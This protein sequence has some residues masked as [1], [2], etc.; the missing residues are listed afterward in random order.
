MAVLSPLLFATLF[1]CN[2][3]HAASACRA[4]LDKRG[5]LCR[6]Y[7]RLT[8][9]SRATFTHRLALRRTVLFLVALL[10]KVASSLKVLLDALLNEVCIGVTPLR[11]ASAI[12]FLFEK[13]CV[14]KRP[15]FPFNVHTKANARAT[16]RTYG[17]VSHDVS[18]LCYRQL[19]HGSATHAISFTN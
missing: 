14:C 1:A 10:L 8:V 16:T 15:K 13:R 2:S 6:K 7:F 11:T 19:L 3:N 9:G 12:T 4:C 17:E 5:S 18:L